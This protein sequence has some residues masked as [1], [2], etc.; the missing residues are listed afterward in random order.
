MPQ[1][2]IP[3]RSATTQNLSDLDLDLSRSLKVKCEGAIGRPI[4]GFLLMFNNNIGPNSAPFRDIRIQNLICKAWV[5]FNKPLAGFNNNLPQFLSSDPSGQSYSL[6]HW[7]FR[8]IHNVLLHWNWYLGSQ[9]TGGG[10]NTEQSTVY[11]MWAIC[12]LVRKCS[13]ETRVTCSYKNKEL[14]LAKKSFY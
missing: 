1:A 11:G 12:A 8:S 9:R 4:Y 6:L 13:Y 10:R 7:R 2:S 5:G 14:F 3:Y